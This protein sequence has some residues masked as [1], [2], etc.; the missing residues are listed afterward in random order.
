M[1]LPMARRFTQKT[2]FVRDGFSGEMLEEGAD[3]IYMVTVK[4]Q[5]VDGQGKKHYLTL[6]FDVSHASVMDL[7]LNKLPP[8][9]IRWTEW[10]PPTEADKTKAKAEGKEA[11]GDSIP[12]KGVVE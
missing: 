12:F 7:L 10:L 4:H 1:V 11:Y 6:A 5:L 8:K 3:S 9:T 2:T